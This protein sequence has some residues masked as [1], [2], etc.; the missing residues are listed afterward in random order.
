M[1][2]PTIKLS[3]PSKTVTHVNAQYGEY[4]RHVHHYFHHQAYFHPSGRNVML[5]L[6]LVVLMGEPG[7]LCVGDRAGLSGL[8]FFLGNPYVVQT[9][10]GA[11]RV[12]VSVQLLV[13]LIRVLRYK[14]RP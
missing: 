4:L 5:D 12:D 1:L 10:A 6:C 9:W 2:F 11:G 13:S 7:R 8:F 3:V 14:C